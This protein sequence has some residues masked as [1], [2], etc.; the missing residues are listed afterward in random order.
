[1]TQTSPTIECMDDV[2]RMHVAFELASQSWKLAFTVGGR[3][4]RVRAI[5]ARDLAAVEEEIAKARRALKVP[6]SAPVVSCYEAGRDGFW[7]HR[8]L[9]GLGIENVVIDPA[10][11]PVDRRAR[12]KKTDRI[13]ARRL[14][15]SLVRYHAGEREVWSVVRVPSASDEDARRGHRELE[16]LTAECT[17]HRNRIG[18]LLTLVGIPAVSMARLPKQ[19]DALR[20]PNGD[21]IPPQLRTE[22]QRQWERWSLAHQQKRAA[23]GERDRVLRDRASEDAALGKVALLA[24]ARGIGVSS[25]TVLVRSSS[26]GGRSATAGS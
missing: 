9:M 11:L 18:S 21:P 4:I 2:S 22:I 12:R 15:E 26:A 19:L 7:L 17:A 13:D 16:C 10:S 8:M 1:M 24:S 14:V 3:K 20:Q 6:E 23:E 5:P 25:A